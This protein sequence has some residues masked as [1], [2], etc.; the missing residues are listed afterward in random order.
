MHLRL[1][2]LGDKLAWLS[3]ARLISHGRRKKSGYG[4]GNDLGADP[5]G[6]T[7]FTET[8]ECRGGS[9]RERGFEV[10]VGEGE[11][12]TGLVFAF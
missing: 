5:A 4:Y 8:G 7:L 2:S 1:G 10:G 12:G 3:C 11:R 9:E 6:K